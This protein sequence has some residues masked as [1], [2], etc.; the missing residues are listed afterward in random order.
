MSVVL[1]TGFVQ[2]LHNLRFENDS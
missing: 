1:E 2:F